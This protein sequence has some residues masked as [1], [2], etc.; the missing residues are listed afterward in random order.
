MRGGSS[1]GDQF[2]SGESVSELRME[3]LSGGEAIRERF[4]PLAAVRIEVFQAYPYLYAGSLDY[5]R[6][7]LETYFASPNAFAALV[8]DGDRC[9]GGS[10]AIPLA[11]ADR[12]MRQPFLGASIDIGTVD[13]FGESVLLAAYR[14]Q[15]LGSKFF[16][17]RER[18][19]RSLGLQHCAFCAVDRPERH[20][21]R[22]ASY[23]PNDAFWTRRGYR[24]QP[25]LVSYYQ[26]VDIGDTES[27]SKPMTFWMR[28]LDA[29]P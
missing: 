28:D 4:E 15:G 12:E 1:V 23:R 8:W 20:P 18:H 6:Q 17:L 22:P 25:A 11:D 9:V 14:G 5:E 26:W 29:C 3:V 27:T 16:E 19:A 13:Y 10:T 24:V 7:Y 2:T 21:Q